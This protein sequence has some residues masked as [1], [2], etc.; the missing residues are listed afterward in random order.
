ML[1]SA[2]VLMLA[3]GA[4][5]GSIG[6][7][8]VRPTQRSRD[9]FTPTNPTLTS[10]TLRHV[11]APRS[12]VP[13]ALGASPASEETRHVTFASAPSFNPFAG[14]ELTADQR[15][16]LAAVTRRTRAAQRVILARQ[17]KGKAPSKED[18]AELKRLADAHNA[19]VR[20]LLTPEQQQRLA[21]NLASLDA[22]YAARAQAAIEQRK[23]QSN[24]ASG[25]KP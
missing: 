15:G 1:R 16:Q 4:L 10:V 6:P 12:A 18:F 20:S 24:A 17:V 5:I 21:A 9:P 23:A 13:Q 3:G 2:I 25:R 22:E 14:L 7:T 11:A 8:L 19:A